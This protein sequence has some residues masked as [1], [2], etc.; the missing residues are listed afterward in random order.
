MNHNNRLWEDNNPLEQQ[1]KLLNTA[2]QVTLVRNEKL[3]G[4]D[5]Y[6]LDI[7]PDWQVLTDWLSVQPP[8]RAPR[9]FNFPELARSLSYRLWVRKD[10]YSVLNSTIEIDYEMVSF[11]SSNS[12]VNFK[13]EINFTDYNKPF[14]IKLP[15]EA[16]N[17]V[18]GPIS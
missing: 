10:S 4:L 3:N 18:I 17:A 6:V 8:W 15:E 11:D 14:E 1:I 5:T 12:T 9:F 7:K 16:L 2:T 13:G